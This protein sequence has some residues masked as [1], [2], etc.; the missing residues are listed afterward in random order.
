MSQK[1]PLRKPR[2]MDFIKAAKVGEKIGEEL[3]EHNPALRS[4]ALKLFEETGFL[5]T[6]MKR[7]TKEFEHLAGKIN[8]LTNEAPQMAHIFEQEIPFKSAFVAGR[9]VKV[10]TV[11]PKGFQNI[12]NEAGVTQLSKV[13]AEGNAMGFDVVKTL[14]APESFKKLYPHL[15]ERQVPNWVHGSDDWIYYQANRHAPTNV[16]L[17]EMGRLHALEYRNPTLQGSL[18]DVLIHAGP[19]KGLAGSRIQMN[20]LPDGSRVTKLQFPGG[21]F[22]DGQCDEYEYIA[23]T[24]QIIGREFSPTLGRMMDRK[25]FLPEDLIGH[26]HDFMR[27]YWTF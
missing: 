7:A 1:A 20:Y 26:V 19:F 27:S 8:I 11:S 21:R 25:E 4:G 10:I 18:D 9:D 3:I 13:H 6:V 24:H 12:W 14:P 5:A 16:I 22:L 2:T 15:A 17:D 23:N